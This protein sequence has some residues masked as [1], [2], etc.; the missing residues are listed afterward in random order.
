MDFRI[1]ARKTRS[2]LRRLYN[3]KRKYIDKSQ[4]LVFRIVLCWRICGCVNNINL[5]TS[6]ANRSVAVPRDLNMSSTQL[7]DTTGRLQPNASANH[8]NQHVE[9][10][11]LSWAATTNT[12]R[13]SNSYLGFGLRTLG[14]Q[15]DPSNPGRQGNCPAIK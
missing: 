1:R 9:Y 10:W 6:A 14:T 5:S 4:Y 11:G 2:N 12:G 13:Q 15:V 3:H 8:D 7:Q